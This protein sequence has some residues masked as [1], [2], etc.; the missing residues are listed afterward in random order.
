MSSMVFG[1]QSRLN[2]VAGYAA[3]IVLYSC[4]IGSGQNSVPPAAA[5]SSP[6]KESNEVEAKSADSSPESSAHGLRNRPSLDL[7]P[8]VRW[9]PNKQGKLVEVPSNATLEEY[10]EYVAK[11]LEKKPEA[12]PSFMVSLIDITGIA[13]DDR[14]KLSVRFVVRLRSEKEWVPVPLQ[15]NEAVLTDPHQYT[16]EGQE[17]PGQLEPDRGYVWWFRGE[18]PH[19]LELSLSVPIRKQLPTRR[20]QLSLPRSPISKLKLTVPYRTGSAK[21]ANLSPVEISPIEG[22]KS[23]IEVYGLGD[24][25]DLN[26]QPISPASPNEPTLEVSTTILAQMDSNAVLLD[27]KQRIHA[28]Q[29][30]FDSYHVTLPVGGDILK[31]EGD[32][33]HSH[34]FLSDSKNRVVVSLKKAT[35]GIVRLHWIVRIPLAERRRLSLD[36][37]AVEGAR[38]QSGEIGLAPYEGMRLSSTQQTNQANMVRIDAALF[39]ITAGSTQVTR[40]FRF[41]SQPFNLSIGIE[42]I[43]PYYLVESRANLLASKQQLHLELVCQYTIHRESLSHVTVHWRDWKAE[44]WTIDGIDPRDVI[45]AGATDESA[46]SLRLKLVKPQNG[47]FQVR[48]RAHRMIKGR[49]DVEFTLPHAEASSPQSTLLVLADDENV[50]TKLSVRGESLPSTMHA[51][52]TDQSSMP[53]SLR[54]LKSTFYRFDDGGQSFQLQVVAKQKRIQTDSMSQATLWNDRLE[55]RQ[56]IGCDVDYE[57]ISQIKFRVP[58]NLLTER[59]R[60]LMGPDSELKADW[61]DEENS[62]FRIVRLTLPEPKSG[63]FEIQAQFSVPVSDDLSTV[64]GTTVPIPILQCTE[65]AFKQAKMSLAT[66][67][68]LEA[69]AVSERWKLL[70]LHSE[71]WNW[72]SETPESQC[73]LKITVARGRSR[74]AGSIERGLITAVIDDSG[75][76]RIRAQ[77]RIATQSSTLLISL[78]PQAESLQIALNRTPLTIGIDAVEQPVRSGKFAIHI[79]ESTKQEIDHLLTIDYQLSCVDPLTFTE[80]LQL[81]APQLPQCFW[82]ARVFWQV[83]L[84]ADRHLFTYPSSATPM[85]VWQRRSLFWYRHSDPDAIALRRWMGADSSPAP[86]TPENEN[87]ATSFGNRYTFSQFGAPRSLSFQSMS[88]SMLVFFGAGLSLLTGFLVLRVSV[89]RHM[90]TILIAVVLLAFVGLWYSGPLEILLQPLVV[91]LLFPIIAI[92][93]ENFFQRRHAGGL[94]TFPSSAELSAA[95]GIRG[96]VLLTSALE[97]RIPPR[98]PT[99]ETEDH[100]RID[101]GSGVS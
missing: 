7:I 61:T 45:Q 18:G 75:S 32:D 97:D 83:V 19:Q 76:G 54:G 69:A 9:L 72:V 51:K 65:G 67:D 88:R 100:L 24:R 80:S 31:I 29:G 64:E 47:S 13:D 50:E 52:A 16:G 59:I 23:Q 77:F 17:I 27:A 43:E 55:V 53:E 94:L 73:D 84:P 21:A 85:F 91:G 62:S 99:L 28:I 95:H 39:P 68:R 1:F 79:P 90:L 26:W 74:G 33:Y 44:G 87:T 10:Y 22:D 56:R 11:R 93:I 66:A 14:A 4:V 40:A 6:R 30:T 42:P 38:K 57:R 41:M 12:A 15:L 63:H 71:S 78:P 98:N 34:R 82:K 20:L 49:D 70:P 96:E 46:N 5:T 25:I 92:V 3:T 81:N 86:L 60:F 58:R 36:G 37:F 35:T 8:A 2:R 89:L 48:L 101:S